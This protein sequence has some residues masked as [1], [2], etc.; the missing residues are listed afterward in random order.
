MIRGRDILTA[1]QRNQAATM[2]TVAVLGISESRAQTD[3]QGER[4]TDGQRHSPHSSVLPTGEH[5][6]SLLNEVPC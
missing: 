3:R 2:V 1:V 6:V 5:Q 4:Q